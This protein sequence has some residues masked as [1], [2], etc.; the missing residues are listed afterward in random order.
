M[1]REANWKEVKVGVVARGGFI[2][3]GEERRRRRVE[4]ARYLA[5]LGGQAQESPAAAQRAPS[6]E[7]QRQ[8]PEPSQLSQPC[9]GCS[10]LK[11]I[12]HPRLLLKGVV[13]LF[14]VTLLF[15][16]GLS[17]SGFS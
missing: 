17:A 12:L 10:R 6:R 16:P 1:H 7:V 3:P 4:D 8:H 15:R 5:V 11:V 13:F 14:M 9:S 2:P